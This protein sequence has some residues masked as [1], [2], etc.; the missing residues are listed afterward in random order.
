MLTEVVLLKLVQLV[1]IEVVLL[2]LVELVL[3]EVVWVMV[4]AVLKMTA[5][6]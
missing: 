6:M 3:I 1:L 4:E 5:W 2:K